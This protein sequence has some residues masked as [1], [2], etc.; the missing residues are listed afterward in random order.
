ME[1]EAA[2]WRSGVALQSAGTV[3]VHGD[4]AGT[5]A[6]LQPA[7]LDVR[8]EK[9][10]LADLFRFLRGKDYGLRGSITLDASAKSGLPSGT[11]RHVRAAESAVAGVWAFSLRAVASR[12]HRWDLTERTDN[13]S[14]VTTVQ[15]TGM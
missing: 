13:P 6:R 3:Q 10:S 14:V 4:I 12:I 7:S 8:W 15:G 2:P 11:D 5:S 1:I 9:V